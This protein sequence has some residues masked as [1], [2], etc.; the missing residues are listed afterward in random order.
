MRRKEKGSKMANE[1]A[2]H[3][4]P[5]HVHLRKVTTKTLVGHIGKT[6]MHLKP[7]TG[8]KRQ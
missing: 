3:T 8:D 2:I 7:E 4:K 1:C 5:R 6:P